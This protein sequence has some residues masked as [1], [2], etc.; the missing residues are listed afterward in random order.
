MTVALGILLFGLNVPLCAMYRSLFI[1]FLKF[2]DLRRA[3]GICFFFLLWLYGLLW[4]SWNGRA[5]GVLWLYLS[6]F[7]LAG[8]LVALSDDLAGSGSS[9]DEGLG[10][11]GMKVMNWWSS[12]QL[13]N[14]SR[15]LMLVL[16][17]ESLL[18][19][20][21]CSARML[22]SAEQEEKTAYLG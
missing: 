15:V 3:V 2:A 9:A 14:Y 16:E 6:C 18:E 8:A 5:H 11:G 1:F 10:A 22:I 4:L 20:V 12:F 19:E 7:D 13:P 17:A 21:H